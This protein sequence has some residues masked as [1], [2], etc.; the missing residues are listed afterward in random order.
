MSRGSVTPDAGRLDVARE[1]VVV[2]R[3]GARQARIAAADALREHAVA[4]TRRFRCAVLIVGVVAVV[5]GGVLLALEI[6]ARHH[7]H[8]LDAGRAASARASAAVTAMLTADP[9]AA[10][11]YADRIIALSVGERQELL[12]TQRDALVAEIGA[13]SASSTGQVIDS[14]LITD[15]SEA[16]DIGSRASVLVVAAGSN[17]E[18]LGAVD[19]AA[20]RPGR[21]TLDVTMQRTDA[22][23]MVA[24]VS[25]V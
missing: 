16:D 12:R 24:A 5:L 6:S 11:D 23:W 3:R 25:A 21:L 8:A 17:P 15:P 13:L 7:Q 2:A 4:R 19:T 10:S 18:L 22:G 9:A 20:T 14:G 1:R